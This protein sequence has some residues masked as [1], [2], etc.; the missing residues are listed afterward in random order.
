M[1]NY[2]LIDGLVHKGHQE[3]STSLFKLFTKLSAP[4]FILVNS[5]HAPVVI[6][7]ME[8]RSRPPT[9]SRPTRIQAHMHTHTHTV[10]LTMEHR[11]RSPTVNHL[12]SPSCRSSEASAR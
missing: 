8:H 5:P 1:L 10:V 12:V 7:T 11:T 9:V 3:S 2:E 4:F 6:L